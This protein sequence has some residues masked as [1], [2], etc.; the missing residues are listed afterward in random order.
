MA[1]NLK[2]AGS[3]PARGTR[4]ILNTFKA[5]STQNC[6]HLVFLPNVTAALSVAGRM[7]LEKGIW[8]S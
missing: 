5:V 1:S 2:V 3:N 7:M 4:F 8:F 6:N